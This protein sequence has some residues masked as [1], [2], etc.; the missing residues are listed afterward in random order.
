[1]NTTQV[2]AI[3]VT[4]H[5]DGGFPERWLASSPQVGALVI[6][7]NGWTRQAAHAAELPEHPAGT[8]S[9]NRT[10]IRRYP[11]IER[12]ESRHCARAQHRHRAR[13]GSRVSRGCS[14]SIRTAASTPGCSRII[15]GI[16]LLPATGAIGGDRS[17]LSRREPAVARCEP[18]ARSACAA[19]RCPWKEVESV[20]TSGSLIPLE[21]HAKVGA[22]REEFFIDYVDSDYCFRARAK[23]LRVIKTR[24]AL[25]SHAIGAAS[26][27]GLLWMNKWTSNHSP[28]RRYYGARNNTVMLREYGHYPFGSWAMKS[29]GAAVCAPASG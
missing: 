26:E 25:M 17:R 3:V 8:A 14:C 12:G 29:S 1:M 21:A 24:Q 19:R 16:R 4:Y 15:R 22:F 28:D 7:D 5:P 20:I 23:G 2:C 13:R 10:A 18:G 9:E 11:G 27:H 6:V